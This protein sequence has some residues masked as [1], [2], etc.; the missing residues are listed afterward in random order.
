MACLIFITC[1]NEKTAEKISMNLLKKKLVA[2][3]NTIPKVK[4][5]YWWEG[6]IE[7]SYESLLIIKTKDELFNSLNREVIKMHPYE[8]PEVIC[9]KINK[10]NKKY[11][12]WIK[13][14]TK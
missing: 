2:C 7:K 4:S 9:V 6:K 3:V 10:G 11:L 8:V 1:P 5:M 14:V 13:E 12:D